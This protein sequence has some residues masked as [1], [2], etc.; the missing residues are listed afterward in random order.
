MRSTLTTPKIKARLKM[1]AKG[2]PVYFESAGK[3]HYEIILEVEGAP[4]NTYA[5]TF[6]LDP[7]YY[8]KIRTVTADK[9]GGLKLET[10]TYGDYVIKVTLRTS[11][12][13][14]LAISSDVKSALGDFKSS[15]KLPSVKEAVSYI[16]R[17]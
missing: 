9:D 12:G 17:H 13:R 2:M 4:E 8:D 16:S 6:E 3:R 7:T 14:E 5:A 10:T 1:D 11:D 15:S